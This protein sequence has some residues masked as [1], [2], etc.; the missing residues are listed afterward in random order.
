MLASR[1]AEPVRPI[2]EYL[3]DPVGEELEYRR[4]SV[5]GAF[6]PAGEVLVRSRTYNSEAG[7]HVVTPLVIGQGRAVMV[8]RGWVPLEMD[9]PPVSGAAPPAAAEVA[10]FLRASQ[11]APALGPADPP[12]GV[13]ARIYWIDLPRLQAQSPH[14]LEPFY[15]QLE[16]QS[17]PQAGSLPV[18]VPAPELSEG[19]HLSYA[20]Q[21]FSFALI[22]L[23]GYG[24]LLRRRRGRAPS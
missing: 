12:E 18:P 10:G 3:D 20:I 16:T 21:W 9:Q 15:V 17:P 22:V 5:S 4:V 6:D 13:L 19:S 2:G 24:A 23:V 1:L 11:S 8:N 14:R 7:F